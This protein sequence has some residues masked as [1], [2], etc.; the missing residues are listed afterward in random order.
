MTK[1]KKVNYNTARA[2]KE[3]SKC[4][5]KVGKSVWQKYKYKRPPTLKNLPLKERW[6]AIDASRKAFK[7]THKKEMKEYD[8][9]WKKTY[10]K[11]NKQRRRLNTLRKHKPKEKC[12]KCHY[13]KTK[14]GLRKV[15]GAWGHCS[16]DMQNCCKDKK[17]ISNK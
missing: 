4:V 10:K 11:C 9:R 12:C 15:R 8:K 6:K 5:S 2:N 16:Y 17:S 3:Y 13:V 14:T 1:R 7:K